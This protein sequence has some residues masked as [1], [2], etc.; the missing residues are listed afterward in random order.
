MST[1][2]TNSPKFLAMVQKVGAASG[3]PPSDAVRLLFYAYY[4][5][6]VNGDA[7]SDGPSRFWFVARAKWEAW[8]Q[9]RGTG[10]P[11]AEAA[12]I[13]LVRDHWPS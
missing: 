13:K 12:Y 2:S 8:A 10:R 5:Q 9:V 6:A 7:P 1:K 3:T 11:A 4:K